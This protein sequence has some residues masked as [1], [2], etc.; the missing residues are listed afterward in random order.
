MDAVFSSPVERSYAVNKKPSTIQYSFSYEEY[1]IVPFLFPGAMHAE[2]VLYNT[3]GLF[4][5]MQSTFSGV[6]SLYSQ[7]RYA[8]A[9]QL[10]SGPI[11]VFKRRYPVFRAFI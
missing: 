3:S 5:T 11:S 6:S 2:D 4:I 8:M 1:A 7:L 10:F 9:G